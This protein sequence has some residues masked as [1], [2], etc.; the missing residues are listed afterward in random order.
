LDNESCDIRF[1]QY[2]AAADGN[3]VGSTVTQA[4]A[5]ISDGLF[6]AER[7]PR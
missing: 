7:R 6:T 2:D 1:S 3:Q 4:N 5:A